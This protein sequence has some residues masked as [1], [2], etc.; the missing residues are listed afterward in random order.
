MRT[1]ARL[2]LG[3]VAVSLSS[4]TAP[5]AAYHLPGTWRWRSLLANSDE[6]LHGLHPLAV[7]PDVAFTESHTNQFGDRRLLAP[8]A[9]VKR[10]PQILVEA[11]S[12]LCPP[13][14]VHRYAVMW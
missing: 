1:D 5:E 14:H 8:G 4:R 7:V 11:G 2:Q 10:D 12:A 9:R 3:Q 6:R 13:W